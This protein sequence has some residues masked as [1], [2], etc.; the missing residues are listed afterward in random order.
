MGVE[1]SAG[2]PAAYPFR[3]GDADG[4]SCDGLCG[5]WFIDCI[6]WLQLSIIFIM[7]PIA[8]IIP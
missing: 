2:L 1:A 7:P 3:S 5:L 8:P 4:V 6:I